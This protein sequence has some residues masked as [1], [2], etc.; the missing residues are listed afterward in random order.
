MPCLLTFVAILFPRSCLQ[1]SGVSFH[2]IIFG[3]VRMEK[4]FQKPTRY[5]HQINESV[6]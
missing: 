4:E 2:F 5:A 1:T 3:N 6:V